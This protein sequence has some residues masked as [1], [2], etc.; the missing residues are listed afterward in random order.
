[1][2]STLQKF[3]PVSSETAAEL[4]ASMWEAAGM[5]AVPDCTT[6][7]AAKLLRAGGGFDVNRDLLERWAGNG[8]VPNVSKGPQGLQWSAINLLQAAGLLNASRRWLLT[9]GHIHK[10][11]AVELEESRAR[12]RGETI[13]TDLDS[14]DYRGLLGVIAN[15]LTDHDT[16]AALC[17]AIRT[18]LERAGIE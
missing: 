18:K 14:M 7:T 11:S 16:R 4:M 1:M 5:H 12:Q 9:S 2:N 17:Q 8:T 15:P 13:F 10:M 3:E 6:A